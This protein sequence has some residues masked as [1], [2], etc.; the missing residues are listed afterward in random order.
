MRSTAFEFFVIE[1]YDLTAKIAESA[2]GNRFEDRQVQVIAR[3][4]IIHQWVEF[5]RGDTRVYGPSWGSPKRYRRR[6][7]SVLLEEH[8]DADTR[9]LL[10]EAAVRRCRIQIIEELIFGKY[11]HPVVDIIIRAAD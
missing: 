5:P 3:I 7:I 8:P 2:K 4:C 11:T 1:N 10:A 9:Q 6:W